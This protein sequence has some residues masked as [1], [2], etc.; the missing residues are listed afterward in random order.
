M[1]N[2]RQVNGALNDYVR[3]VRSNMPYHLVEVGRARGRG[4]EQRLD[5]GVCVAAHALRGHGAA[6]SARV[7]GQQSHSKATAESVRPAEWGISA[8]AAYHAEGRRT[9]TESERS[10]T[11]HHCQV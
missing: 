8:H 2:S 1:H 9:S 6:M 3:K 4:L 5:A 11:V 10:V 7:V